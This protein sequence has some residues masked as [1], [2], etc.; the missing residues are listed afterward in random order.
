[1]NDKKITFQLWFDKEAKDARDFY[2]DI[3]KILRS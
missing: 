2:L 1:M 3:L